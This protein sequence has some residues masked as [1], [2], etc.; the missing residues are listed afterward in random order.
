MGRAGKHG[1]V[2]SGCGL[3]CKALS[4]QSRQNQ[5]NIMDLKEA[6]GDSALKVG[7]EKKNFLGFL[8]TQFLPLFNYQDDHTGFAHLTS[9]MQTRFIPPFTS[10]S[11]CFIFRGLQRQMYNSNKTTAATAQN[12]SLTSFWSRAWKMWIQPKLVEKCSTL[13]PSSWQ[14][15]QRPQAAESSQTHLL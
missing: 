12:N 2:L 4:P 13:S 7:V 14:L 15:K 8:L 5:G 10:T 11:R 1:W 3:H 6:R 9:P